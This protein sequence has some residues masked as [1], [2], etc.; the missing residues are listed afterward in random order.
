MGSPQ[1]RELVV[2]ACFDCHSNEVVWPWYAEIAPI[3]WLVARDVDVGRAK[4]NFSSWDQPQGEA[5]ECVA[6]VSA[7]EMPP[8]SYTL[9]H[10]RARLSP[11]ERD[12]LVLVL[13][14]IT[15]VAAPA[16][17]RTHD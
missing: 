14:A 12:Q 11:G 8:W 1:A 13:A 2:R 16:R 10:P 17:G 3:S 7:G 4:L 6:A 9:L 5:E 15:G